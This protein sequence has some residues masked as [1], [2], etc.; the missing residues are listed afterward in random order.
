MKNFIELMKSIMS[1]AY[2]QQELDEKGIIQPIYCNEDNDGNIYFDVEGMREEF[3]RLM[4]VMEEHNENSEFDWD[5][6]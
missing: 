6:F 2:T 5:N 4:E 1:E 3:E